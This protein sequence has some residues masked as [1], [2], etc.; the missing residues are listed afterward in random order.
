MS[1]YV[2]VT[3]DI[4]SLN[5]TEKYKTTLAHELLTIKSVGIIWKTIKNKRSGW[6]CICFSC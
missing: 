4:L 5:T 2:I 3:L 1:A 6:T